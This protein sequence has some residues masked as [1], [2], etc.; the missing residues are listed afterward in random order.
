MTTLKSTTG[1]MGLILIVGSSFILPSSLVAVSAQPSTQPSTQASTKT[2]FACVKKGEDPAT[3]AVRGDIKTSPM[4]IWK[5]TSY[6]TYT[7]QK[8]C[9]IVSQRLTKA[10]ATSGKLKNL[11]MTHGIINSLPVICYITRKG[12][13]CNANNILFS[14][15]SSER[16]Q[17]QAIVAGLLDFSKLGTSGALMRGG[18]KPETFGD[19]IEQQLTASDPVNGGG[20]E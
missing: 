18:A 2:T 17:E 20:Q 5:D 3:I 4:I 10:V 13:K 1:L 15:K 7:P 11:N 9:E 19:A 12:E 16:G 8:R 6:G 14:L